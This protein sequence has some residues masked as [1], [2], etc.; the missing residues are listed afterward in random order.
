MVIK[1]PNLFDQDTIK[2]EDC[3]H[4]QIITDRHTDSA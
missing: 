2:I 4:K 1:Q 3:V